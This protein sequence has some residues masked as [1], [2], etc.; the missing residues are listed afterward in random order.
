M[1]FPGRPFRAIMSRAFHRYRADKTSQ[2]IYDDKL[3]SQA[4]AE[5]PTQAVEP[6]AGSVTEPVADSMIDPVIDAVVESVF[7]K[8][9]A[10]A[11]L[12]QKYEEATT[13]SPFKQ[14]SLDQIEETVEGENEPL[15][16]DSEPTLAEDE[17][18][19]E[20]EVSAEPNQPAVEPTIEPTVQPTVQPSAQP[21]VDTTAQPTAEI[22]PDSP[23]AVP[24]ATDQAA[25][26]VQPVAG[27]VEPEPAE[28][29]V[30]V[31]SLIS[32]SMGNIFQKKVTKDP[33]LQALLDRHP[34]EDMRS[35]A[36]D[37]RAFSEDIG[38][39]EKPE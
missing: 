24:P 27:P 5:W 29:P 19:T 12:S 17:A 32:N 11:D 3:D 37:L 16:V 18:P 30:T 36:E 10:P 20:S 14:I 23:P 1:P 8:S 21:T 39:S 38:A 4:T 35:L 13:A 28:P 33:L 2:D 9:E 22:T 7:E 15:A 26:P 25:E 6:T 34:D 31:D